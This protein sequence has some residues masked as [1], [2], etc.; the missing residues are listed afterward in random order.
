MGNKRVMKLASRGKRFGAYCIDAIVPVFNLI[1]MFIAIGIFSS[2]YGRR[3]GYGNN[4]GYGWG[5]GFGNDYGNG[6]GNGYGYGYGYGGGRSAVAIAIIIGII[7]L[8][9]IAYMAVQ[10]IFFSKSKTMGK[11]ALGLQVISAEDGKPIGFWKMILREW[12]V[13]RAS[14]YVFYLGFIWILI[15]DKNRGW[16]DKILDT[17]VVDLKE[18]SKL[19]TS[20]QATAAKPQDA[21]APVQ[22]IEPEEPMQIPAVPAVDE[23]IDVMP[24]ED[25][26]AEAIEVE[27]DKSAVEAAAAI[28][29][30]I[31]AIDQVVRDAVKTAPKQSS[32]SMA[33]KKDELLA[34]AKDAGAEATDKMTKA[35]IIEAIE[36]VT[37]K[38]TEITPENK[39]EENL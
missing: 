4:F 25:A 7:T 5:N 28:E 29:Q 11:A 19:K 22:E 3:Y 39:D 17:Y 12:I 27:E 6:F 33:M 26:P 8:L 31:P 36:K 37:S 23:T 20:T 16:H 2:G 10:L 13:K 30:A 34:A 1:L 14:A 35:E 24:A 38:E 9:F 15:D 32:V 21:P 18:S